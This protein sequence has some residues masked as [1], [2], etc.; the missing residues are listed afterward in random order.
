MGM[1]APSQPEVLYIDARVRGLAATHRIVAC[2]P[3][4]A[5]EYIDDLKSLCYPTDPELLK[6][7]WLIT[8][9]AKHWC[10]AIE[11]SDDRV[12]LQA[13]FALNTPYEC[14]YSPLS[15]L[16]PRTPLITI[17]VNVEEALVDLSRRSADAR[18][19]EFV[20]RCGELG[21]ALAFEPMTHIAQEMIPC[22]AWTPNARLELVTR[23]TYTEPLVALE[24]RGH[25]TI[26]MSVA[27]QRIIDH[28]EQGTPSLAERLAAVNR[29]IA[30]GYPVVCSVD[31]IIQVERWQD[32][33]DEL[34]DQIFSTVTLQGLQRIELSCF[35]HP[36]GLARKA[37]VRFPASRIFLGE[38]VPV[39]GNYR[40]FRP[41]RQRIYHFLTESI[42]RRAETLPIAI[43]KEHGAVLDQIPSS[44]T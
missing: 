26:V 39:N 31:P 19:T 6:K 7:R 41:V 37:A 13:D 4:A 23:T 5:V 20:V 16:I 18:Q 11:K 1:D 24:H 21:D 2:C 15:V 34:I 40:Y 29:L 42:R 28:E 9:T 25:T 22:F 27:P 10:K 38:L 32:A 12:V 8:E 17:M 30:D 3:D 33:Y 14:S 35:H 36:R 43:T 44:S